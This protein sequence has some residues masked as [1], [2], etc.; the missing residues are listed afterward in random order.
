M[1][2]REATAGGQKVATYAR[3]PLQGKGCYAAREIA[4]PRRET[5]MGGGRCARPGGRHTKARRTLCQFM[6]LPC[7]CQEAAAGVRVVAMPHQEAT[8]ECRCTKLGVI[9]GGR[10]FSKRKDEEREKGEKSTK[11][12]KKRKKGRKRRRRMA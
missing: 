3:R 10:D 2:R 12:K 9:A 1:P 8:T 7:L 4:M 5:P 11:K 6:T